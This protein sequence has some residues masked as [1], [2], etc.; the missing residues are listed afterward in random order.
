MFGINSEDITKITSGKKFI[1]EHLDSDPSALALKGAEA[2]LC[3]QIKM[4]QKCKSKLP[5]YY[6]AVCIIPPLSYE[7][8]SSYQ[9]AYA[10]EYSGRR[11][12][13][14]TCGLGVDSERFSKNFD[15]VIAIERDPLLA[16]IAVRNFASL[17][18]DNV[19]VI[20]ADCAV[21]LSEY[22]GEPFDIVYCDP[23][24][25][26]EN[27]RTFLLSDCSP[28]IISLLDDIKRISQRLVIKMS[29]LFDV[30]EALRLFPE[31]SVE[32]VSLNGECKEVLADIDFAKKK[33]S[34]V[35]C[36]VVN[37]DGK[38]TK[39]VFPVNQTEPVEKRDIIDPQFLYIAD[40]AFK[41]S[42]MP[43]RLMAGYFPEYDYEI[44]GTVVLGDILINDFPGRKYSIK[45]RFDYKPK[46]IKKYLRENEITSATVVKENFSMKPEEVRKSLGLKDGSGA[47]IITADIDGKPTVFIAEEIAS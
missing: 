25:R 31:C 41:K 36:T 14:L 40:V 38:Y 18:A 30:E 37:T 24:R 13:D 35:I 47:L 7:Q 45:E 9:T 34:S 15:E 8:S 42:K 26:N 33:E 43:A 11:L 28:D 3:T 19:H 4:L 5:H 44:H 2:C 21:F 46:D 20:N 6:N 17:G 29:P 23:A 10:K 16:E 22:D 1:T 32:V 39:Y 27:K 12:L